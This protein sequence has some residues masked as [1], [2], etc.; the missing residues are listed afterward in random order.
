MLFLLKN[1]FKLFQNNS[2]FHIITIIRYLILGA[3]N[4]VFLMLRGIM[5][6]KM[7][8]ESYIKR[9]KDN[10]SKK[11]NKIAKELQELTNHIKDL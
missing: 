9:K 4:L 2:T 3:V 7:L 11:I 8:A 1:P 10:L 5:K 6:K